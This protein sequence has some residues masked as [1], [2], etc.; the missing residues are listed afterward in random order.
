MSFPKILLLLALT[1]N[2][3]AYIIYISILYKNKIKAHG[4][5]YLVWAI[6][7]GLNFAIQI[8][9]GVGIS[10][11]LLGLNFF[12]CCIVCII[13]WRKN[14]IHYDRLDWICFCLA[15]IAVILWLST[16]TPIYSVVLSCIIDF[17]AF[18]PSFRKS[19]RFPWDDSPIVY[20][21]SGAEYLLSIPSYSSFSVINLLY[22]A[23]LIILDFGYSIFIAVRRHQ[24]KPR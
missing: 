5:T 6:I 10:S 11:I 15:I 14:L 24:L 23:C 17:L 18:I 3:I 8:A 21:T 13:L 2:V 12:G 19:F 16:K 4:L 20:W 22:P 9:S 1:S 7:L